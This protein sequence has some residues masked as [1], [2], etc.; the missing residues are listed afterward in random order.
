MAGYSCRDKASSMVTVSIEDHSKNMGRYIIYEIVVHIQQR[1]AFRC[2]VEDAVPIIADL[3]LQD[4]E[5]RPGTL[6]HS[7]AH[8][9]PMGSW[10]NTTGHP[11]SLQIQKLCEL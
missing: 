2:A 7:N 1:D 9:K 6:H 4:P 3:N 8:Q 5:E 11:S 10:A